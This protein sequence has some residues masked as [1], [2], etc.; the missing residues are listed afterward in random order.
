MEVGDVLSRLEEVVEERRRLRTRALVRLVFKAGPLRVGSGAE[1]GEAAHLPVAKVET[2][3]GSVPMIFESSI[4]GVLR[5][6]SEWLVK[7]SLE[8]LPD[9]VDREFAS[10]HIEPEERPVE[11]FHREDGTVRPFDP[12][13]FEKAVKEDERLKRLRD[14]ILPARVT[15]LRGYEPLA[16]LLC[17]ICRLWGGLGLRGKVV[18]ADVL[19]DGAVVGVRTHVGISRRAG[20]REEGILYT[21]E[22]VYPEKVVIDLVVENVVP[23]SS[24]ALILASTLE[25]VK[26]LGLEVGGFKSR[27][28]GMLVLDREKSSVRYVDYE[29]LSGDDL[30]A[31]LAKPEERGS[32]MSIAEFVDLLRGELS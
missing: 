5:R 21:A 31:A 24:E 29:R 22:Y 4:R 15:G 16:A 26:E 27:G 14:R 12:R 10:S 28:A 25:G 32:R 20:V 9:E 30:L 2:P 3:K 7:A 6:V 23:G 13:E 18:I 1:R 17:P 19:L 8:A 11:H